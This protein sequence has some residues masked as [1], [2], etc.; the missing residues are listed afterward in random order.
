M[1][2][3]H[4]AFRQHWLWILVNIAA[5]VPLLWL[6]YDILLQNLIDPVGELTL[7]TGKAAS[8]ASEKATDPGMPS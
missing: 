7:R 4:N 1:K 5:L 8:L 2:S 3:I 6:A